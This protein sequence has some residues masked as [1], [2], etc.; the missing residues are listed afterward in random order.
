MT[1]AHALIA[2]G[3]RKTYGKREVVGGVSL[4]V[5]KGSIVGLLG[6]NGAGKSTTF[7]MIAGIVKP[8]AGTVSLGGQPVTHMPLYKRARAGLGYLPQEASVFRKLSVR[9][10]LRA[11]LEMYETNK[12]AREDRAD[13]LLKRFK[14]SHVADS[15]GEALSGGER[16]RCE[17]ARAL[18]PQPTHLMF[19]EPFAGVDPIAV[20]DIQSV[21]VELARE[22]GI[23]VLIT[24][25][26]VRETLG[27]CDTA[28][29]VNSGQVLTS[30]TPEAIAAHPEARRAYL[31]ADFTL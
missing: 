18:V 9:D 31:G 26:A 8:S 4:R 28:T 1:D 17:I 21:V 30:G 19:D 10:N 6:P 15:P 20:G 22:E 14:L 16:R 29:I 24:D 2:D 5:P 7:K 3:L 12:S 11:V 25:H 23:G 13:A 27:I